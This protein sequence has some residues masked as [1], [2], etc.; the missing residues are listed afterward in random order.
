MA[1]LAIAFT[2]L[3]LL[4]SAA[5]DAAPKGGYVDVNGVHMYYEILGQGE[6]LILLDGG[7][8]VGEGFGVNRDA[9][10]K[11]RQVISVHTQGLGNTPDIDR[12][13]SFE[14][15]ADDVAAL[16]AKLKLDHVDVIGWSYGGGMALQLAI[17]HP[18]LVRKLV[19]VG[20]PMSRE[21]WYPEVNAVFPPMAKDP[22]KFVVGIDKSPILG[23][24][25]KLYPN[26]DWPRMFRKMGEL[27]SQYYDWSKGVA[28]LKMPVMLVF[29]DA[30]AV[31]TEHIAQ[32]YKALGGGMR[33]AGVDGAKRPKARLAI[34]PDRTHYTIMK[35]TAVA[36]A[37]EPFLAAK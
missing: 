28:A 11:T 37:V 34:I 13:L 15:L 19:V 3:A 8:M 22:K 33:D 7:F 2:A 9:F 1:K 26:V 6:P 16:A 27:E 32:F 35:T 10:A 25:V 5:A 23:D 36:E 18:K 20:Q 24:T 29:A 4:S 17:R 12:P 21:G 31:S 14:Q 30:D